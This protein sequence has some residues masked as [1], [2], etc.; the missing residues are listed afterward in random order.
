MNKQ[1]FKPEFP[2]IKL[3]NREYNFGAWFSEKTKTILSDLSHLSEC[4]TKIREGK[5]RENY[6][7]D[8]E[9]DDCLASALVDAVKMVSI[10][11]GC[12]DVYDKSDYS[13][14]LDKGY[15]GYKELMR[16]YGMPTHDDIIETKDDEIRIKIRS[17]I[18]GNRTNRTIIH[19][20]IREI[21][22]KNTYDNLLEDDIYKVSMNEKSWEWFV[23]KYGQRGEDDE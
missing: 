20:L 12:D 2:E 10:I 3:S 19:S 6:S 5:T 4:I 13:L 23:D 16:K 21:K 15:D 11:D 22:R 1:E 18:G 7:Y 8:E 9:I 17:Y 14:I